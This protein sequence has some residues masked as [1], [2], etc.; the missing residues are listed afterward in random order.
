MSN[1]DNRARN[2]DHLTWMTGIVGIFFCN[3]SAQY[4]Q[5]EQRQESLCRQLSI[6]IEE[7]AIWN[8]QLAERSTPDSVPA[9]P[10][11]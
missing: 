3:M 4:L 9:G 5:D 8:E 11:R 7:L 6:M 1:S 2:G 10:D